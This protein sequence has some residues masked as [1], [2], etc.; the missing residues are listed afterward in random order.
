MWAGE[1]FVRYL[2]ATLY[3][4]LTSSSQVVDAGVCCVYLRLADLKA[5]LFPDLPNDDEL[6]SASG[7]W[8]STV[9]GG[10]ENQQG[11]RS[12]QQGEGGRPRG[13][14][15]GGQQSAVQFSA[16]QRLPPLAGGSG[17][18]KS[19]ISSS[20]VI[21]TPKGKMQVR[22]LDLREACFVSE[23]WAA[24]FLHDARPPNEAV[25][26][27]LEQHSSS[28][29]QPSS[30]ML[31]LMRERF[32]ASSTT[33]LRVFTRAS[34]FD[35]L[36]EV[37][38][39]VATSHNLP[40]TTQLVLLFLPKNGPPERR[41]QLHARVLSISNKSSFER[42][43]PGAVGV[44][45]ACACGIASAVVPESFIPLSCNRAERRSTPTTTSNGGTGIPS[46]ET[47]IPF[48][49]HMHQPDGTAVKLGGEVFR[50]ATYQ[51]QVSPPVAPAPELHTGAPPGTE[52]TRAPSSARKKDRGLARAGTTQELQQGA[53]APSKSTSK[54]MRRI[55][56][57]V[58][59]DKER[60]ESKK[61]PKRPSPNQ[62]S[63][64]K[65][66]RGGSAVSLE[67]ETKKQP[68]RPSPNQVSTPKISRGGSAVSLEE[69][70]KKQPKRPSPNQVSTPK[71]S[72]G[73]SAVSLEAA[74]ASPTASPTSSATSAVATGPKK[75]SRI[76]GRSAPAEKY[77]F[78]SA[79]I[80][81]TTIRS[82]RCLL[83]SS[84]LLSRGLSGIL[85]SGGS[86][87]A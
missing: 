65:I 87:E 85:P 46:S 29:T 21:S 61:P 53:P 72:R 82:S 8:E 12:I 22:A 34:V 37:R 44:N 14:R 62:V 64:P 18:P 41:N 68:K 74:T 35:L 84:A 54:K 77:S 19:S 57:D 26:Q 20:N 33:L 52:H 83:D 40:P 67:E 79:V 81:V 13:S 47:G 11:R 23:D 32:A 30:S 49:V 51:H 38:S 75:P 15:S 31:S 1:L 5:M 27:A 17:S 6:W 28:I 9:L 66:S 70:T 36:E 48:D 3:M 76:F 63:T 73:G 80:T 25:D 4:R 55:N 7:E 16:E 78:P 39:R 86:T 59:E 2:T 50:R 56:S 45:L 43:L 58:K 10:W 69:E 71:I 42:N 24:D 60:S